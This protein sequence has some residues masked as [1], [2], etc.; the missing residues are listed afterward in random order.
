MLLRKQIHKYGLMH[1][2]ETEMKE[3]GAR[4]Q[5][6]QLM[7]KESARE[8]GANVSKFVEQLREVC[9]HAVAL[10]ITLKSGDAYILS[11]KFD[12]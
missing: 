3:R 10:V 4:F 8:A 1:Q 2:V 6:W 7:T 9:V 5:C 12:G 11:Q